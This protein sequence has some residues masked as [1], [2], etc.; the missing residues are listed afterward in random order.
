MSYKYEHVFFV[1]RAGD[2]SF[3]DCEMLKASSKQ[4]Q[5][6]TVEMINLIA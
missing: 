2:E 5:K 3:F 4:Q 6:T 1:L